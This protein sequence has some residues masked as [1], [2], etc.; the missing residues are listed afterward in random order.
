MFH[1]G[2]TQVQQILKKDSIVEEFEGKFL[3]NAIVKLTFQE[4][5]LKVA[6]KLGYSQFKAKYSRSCVLVYKCLTAK[7]G[8]VCKG[9]KNKGKE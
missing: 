4:K 1:C 3:E 9:D 7:Y 8:S 6:E 5:A 2:R